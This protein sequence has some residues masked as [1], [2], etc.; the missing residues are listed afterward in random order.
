MQLIGLMSR[1]VS[2]GRCR[3]RPVTDEEAL[4]Q[5]GE[6]TDVVR[7]VLQ[8]EPRENLQEVAQR[9]DIGPHCA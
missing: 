6:V 2:L 8:F 1:D 5:W 3:R 4:A 7:V 9:G